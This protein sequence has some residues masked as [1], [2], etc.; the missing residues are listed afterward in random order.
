LTKRIKKL[1]GLFEEN[2][3][4][5]FLVTKDTNSTYLTNFPSE[6][7]WLLVSPKRNHYITDG[8][9]VLAAREG[10]KGITVKPYSKSIGVALFDSI[11]TL[12][13]KRLGFDERHLSLF[14]FRRLQHYCPTDVELV[15]CNELVEQLRVIK[16]KGEIDLI[17]KAIS[18][19][20]KAFGFIKENL[21]PGIT[22]KE[23]LFKTEQY[24]K[25]N[26]ATFSFDPIMASGPN[27]CYPHAKVT[28]RKI[29]NNEPVLVDMG[30]DIKGYKSD[31][32][33]MFFLGKITPLFQKTYEAV[34]MA[35]KVAIEKIRPCIEASEI[36]KQA[37]KY[38]SKR[39]L[40]K[41]FQHSLG[42]GVGLEIHEAPQV[43]TKSTVVLKE[44]MVLTV[45]PA[46][47]LP[48][49]FGIRIEDMVLVTKTGCKVLS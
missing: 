37:R 2:R 49:K 6:D 1:I 35:R 17:K 44:N 19:N 8:R 18:L 29:R 27:S 43:S 26:G 32:T 20:Q 16:D 47:Y 28:D 39:K 12:N 46:V 15:A 4:D 36:D 11:K 25:G 42:H 30:I 22:E 21:K 13:I 33:R 45:E 24:V 23:L 5:A 38:L 34:D 9:Y 31:L 40:G 41:Y 48:S 10:L 3:I 7:S 14:A